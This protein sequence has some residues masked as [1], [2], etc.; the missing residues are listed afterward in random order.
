METQVLDLDDQASTSG[1]GKQLAQI[2]TSQENDIFDIA[3]QQVPTEGNENK[4]KMPTFASQYSQQICTPEYSVAKMLSDENVENA[5]TK[6][7]KQRLQKHRWIFQTSS[8]E[9]EEDN[10]LEFDIIPVQKV[11]PKTETSLQEVSKSSAAKEISPNI[12]SSAGKSEKRK[13]SDDTAQSSVPDSKRHRTNDKSDGGTSSKTK[14]R[15]LA[16]VLKKIDVEQAQKLVSVNDKKEKKTEEKKRENSSS[17]ADKDSKKT[18]Q[19]SS[20]SSEKRSLR[21]RAHQTNKS[22]QLTEP[23]N[24]KKHRKSEDAKEGRDS[25]EYSKERSVVRKSKDRHDDIDRSSKPKDKYSKSKSSHK[26][27]DSEKLVDEIGE[28]IKS[29]SKSSS[30]SRSKSSIKS[31]HDKTA[32]DVNSASDLPVTRSKVCIANFNL[33]ISN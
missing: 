27:K 13:S 17:N 2:D 19:T 4:F 12:A 1:I 18:K 16:V 33:F 30:K 7:Q 9:D 29:S 10:D 24:I 15:H 3:T 21:D 5:L 32:E 8:D 20:R 22:E 26:S 25:V 6:K 11:A 31:T 28:K 23:P 14:S